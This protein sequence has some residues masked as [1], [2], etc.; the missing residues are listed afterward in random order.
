[1]KRPIRNM[2]TGL[3]SASLGIY[4]LAAPMTATVHA[5]ANPNSAYNGA[6]QMNNQNK[7]RQL[8]A[9]TGKNGSQN[10]VDVVKA[11]AGRLGFDAQSDSFSLVSENTSTAIVQVI[12]QGSTHKVTLK[13]S[14]QTTDYAPKQDVKAKAGNDQKANGKANADGKTNSGSEKKSGV[15]AQAGK[16][17]NSGRTPAQDQ[18]QKQK[19]GS[20][21]GQWVIVS[22][23]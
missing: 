15:N 17:N 3:L 2:V 10:P 6:G 13:R 22:V 4:M 8:Q 19:A 11:E 18:G 9:D 14:Q 5:S 21:Q 12:H 20:G 16:E 1:M 23:D 7:N